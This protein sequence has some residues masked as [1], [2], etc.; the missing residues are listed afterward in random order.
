MHGA[1]CAVAVAHPERDKQQPAQRR[2][3]IHLLAKV[4][5][6]KTDRRGAQ[7]VPHVI[8]VRLCW[9]SAVSEVRAVNAWTM[10][11]ALRLLQRQQVRPLSLSDLLQGRSSR[12]LTS[13]RS[14]HPGR[15]C[16]THLIAVS[17]DL[18]G[19]VL[20]PDLGLCR[21]FGAAATQCSGSQGATDLPSTP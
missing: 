6:R 1:E 9:R 4:H 20:D 11:A 5:K 12:C 16:E 18:G 8:Q 19:R 10:C 7:R 3:I 2:R 17:A 14:T 13:G 15:P 21:K